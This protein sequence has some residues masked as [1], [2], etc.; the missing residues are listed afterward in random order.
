MTPTLNVPTLTTDRLTLRAHVATDFEPLAAFYADAPR[1]TGFGGPLNRSDA[2]RWFALSIGHWA[3]HGYGYWTVELTATGEVCGIVGLWNPEGW[4]EP[5]LGWAMFENSEGKGFAYEAALKVREFA[6]DSLG[7][8]TLTSLIIP[9]NI[10]SEVLAKR[11]GATYERT[12]ENVHMGTEQLFRH[13][14]PEKAAR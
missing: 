13:P 12:F 14:A 3:L 10:R 6:Y 8:T 11:V 5:E 2:W 4:P 9:G 1:S 7:F